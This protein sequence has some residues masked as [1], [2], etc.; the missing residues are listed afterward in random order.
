MATKSRPLDPLKG[1]S[2]LGFVNHRFGALGFGA[3]WAGFGV[4][5]GVLVLRL[6]LCLFGMQGL[7]FRE[8]LGGSWDLVS[9]VIST[10][11]GVITN[12]NYS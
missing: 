6:L 12:Y 1:L 3:T 5:S 11:T 8:L 4:G 7:G 10:L 9:T 2:L